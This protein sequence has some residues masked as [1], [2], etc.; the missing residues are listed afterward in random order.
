MLKIKLAF[1]LIFALI[2][3]LYML[4]VGANKAYEG[5]KNQNLELML[6]LTTTRTTVADY[7]KSDKS[8]K[9]V[10]LTDAKINLL[11]AVT[12]TTTTTTTNN[13][14]HDLVSSKKELSGLYI[15]I[16]SAEFTQNDTV[17]LLLKTNDTGLIYF[18]RQLKAMSEAKS[19]AE[20][21][22]FIVRERAKLI[23]SVELSGLMKRGEG[24]EIR[25]HI[26]NLAGEF[27]VLEHNSSPAMDSELEEGLIIMG[28]GLLLLTPF[29]IIFL[30][31]RKARMKAAAQVAALLL[32]LILLFVGAYT[33]WKNPA[34]IRTT[35]ADYVKSDKSKQWVVLTDAKIN[36]LNAV[37]VTTTTTTTNNEK[38]I[39]V[40]VSSLYIPIESTGFTQN[41]T[42]SLLLET[43]DA[44]ILNVARQLKAKSEAKSEAELLQFFVKNRDKPIH[45]VELAGLVESESSMES[46]KAQE[47]RKRIKNLAGD[48]Y[49]L[50]HNQSELGLTGGLIIMGIGLLL[51]ILSIF[52]LRR[53]KEASENLSKPV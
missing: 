11:N 36:L 16:E 18:A 12:V 15:P 35:V 48:F 43:D 14:T 5:W 32:S 30:L 49:I 17:S 42:V 28:I 45:S 6:E 20:L 41:D 26:K 33:S 31:R 7:V 2:S 24:G 27:Y 51:L 25:K 23:R 37:T 46:S 40:P 1:A 44:E 47:I 34:P 3:C 21:L 29:I 52:S 19:E 38:I 13:K 50:K 8:K 10:V 9:W 39:R 4:Y 22:Q 53:K